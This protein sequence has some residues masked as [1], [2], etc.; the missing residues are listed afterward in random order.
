MLEC[1]PG[2]VRLKLPRKRELRLTARAAAG[3]GGAALNRWWAQGGAEADA[4]IGGGGGRGLALPADVP[5]LD[6]GAGLSCR[7][8]VVTDFSDVDLSRLPG[9]G[10]AHTT[11]TQPG[12]G[13]LDQKKPQRAGGTPGQTLQG[14]KPGGS[15]PG[16]AQ[17]AGRGL[18]QG[19]QVTPAAAAAAAAVA[20]APATPAVAAAAAPAAAA[21]AGPYAVEVRG[22][23]PDPGRGLALALPP[24]PLGRHAVRVGGRVPGCQGGW[25]GALKDL[26]ESFAGGPAFKGMPTRLP[27]RPPACLESTCAGL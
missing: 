1:D 17:A 2:A 5:W 24:E 26:K 20:A 15:T 22:Q 25:Q 7:R 3:G 23:W 14:A 6:W 18:L 19:Q 21:V 13:A 27:A 4:P 16:Q 9:P 8:L 10:P 11:T 12:G